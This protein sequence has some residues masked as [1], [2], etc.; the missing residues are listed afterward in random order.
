[1]LSSIL[2]ILKL[3]LD[4]LMNFKA[5]DGLITILRK[6]YIF[7]QYRSVNYVMHA[8]KEDKH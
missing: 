7:L 5:K 3:L 2:L 8:F 6:Y 1:M 4:F